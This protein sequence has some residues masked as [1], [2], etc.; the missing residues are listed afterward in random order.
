MEI[1]RA[2]KFVT[3]LNDGLEIET[4]LLKMETYN[5]LCVSSQVGCSRGCSFCE[6]GKMGL[7]RNLSHEEI[8]HQ[9]YRARDEYGYSIR[10]IVF[11]G[12]GEPL[13]NFEQVIEA[14]HVFSDPRGLNIPKGRITI[15][16]VGN[17]KG[18]EKLASLA[19]NN[20]GE[21][22]H[23]IRLAVSLNAPTDSIRSSLMPINRQYPLGELKKTLQNYPLAKTR[24]RILLEYV[25]IPG[26]NDDPGLLPQLAAFLE[27]LSCFVNFIPH[28]P[29]CSYEEGQ[30]LFQKAKDYGIPCRIREERGR[31][32]KGGCGQLTGGRGLS[33]E[34]G[35]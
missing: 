30:V 9:F 17:L 2:F 10:N 35:V 3:T 4:V 33:S 18:I 1:S 25:I 15:S 11:M 26:V 7:K 8:L 27:G 32:I 31:S 23:R 34:Q 29:L 5:T 24:D 22:Y 28:N 19:R 12:M 21:L 6:T 16:T 20:Q 13:D 14:I